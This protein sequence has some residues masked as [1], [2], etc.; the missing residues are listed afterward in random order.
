MEILT[1][2]NGD[3]CKIPAPFQAGT[4]FFLN[5]LGFVQVDK[6]R[7]DGGSEATVIN[8]VRPGGQITR[9]DLSPQ[10]DT[11]HILSGS[12][13]AADERKVRVGVDIP[14]M[15]GS[16]FLRPQVIG[17]AVEHQL[18]DLA[19]PGSHV[20]CPHGILT[21]HTAAF[22]RAI[23]STEARLS[24]VCGNQRPLLSI[25]GYPPPPAAPR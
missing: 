6:G 3:F 18:V 10:G 24:D 25:P 9:A 7:V 11:R 21:R 8:S 1:L 23:S 4:L 15:S 20:G 17:Q 19:Q 16:F 12:D 13:F 2:R 5:S 22:L 14:R